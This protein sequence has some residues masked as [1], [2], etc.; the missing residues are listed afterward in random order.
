MAFFDSTLAAYAAGRRVALAVLVECDFAEGVNRFWLT[1]QGT[2]EAGG[3]DWMGTGE[4]V[5]TSAIGT[6]Q[7][8][9]ADKMEFTLSGVSTELL[10]LAQDAESV[11]GQRITVY[12]QFLDADSLQPYDDM[13]PLPTADVMSTIGFAATGPGQRAITIT[14]ESI[15]AARDRAR[16]AFYTVR[17]QEERFPG[18]RGLEYI[19]T[20]KNKEVIWPKYS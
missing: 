3:Y 9:G 11:R 18:D 5:S 8:D 12:G 13:W 4:L 15:F 19:P 10:A 14:A 6:G 1:G 7:G 2:L 20:L 16:Y 17:D